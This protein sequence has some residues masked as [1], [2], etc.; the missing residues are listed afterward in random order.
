MPSRSKTKYD[1]KCY[2]TE[3]ANLLITHGIGLHNCKTEQEVLDSNNKCIKLAER[4]IER[5]SPPAAKLKA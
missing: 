2:Y 3:L 1:Y 4:F 5:V